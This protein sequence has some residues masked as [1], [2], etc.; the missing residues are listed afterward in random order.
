MDVVRDLVA[1]VNTH[2][3]AAEVL[4]AS[5]RHPRHVTEAALAGTHVATVPFTI[6]R[7]MIH[8]PLTDAGILRFRADWEAVQSANRA[9]SAP[10]P[11]AA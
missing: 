4:A 3:L 6:L 1:I 11:N 7:A 10:V 5:I 9:P 2:E 8:H